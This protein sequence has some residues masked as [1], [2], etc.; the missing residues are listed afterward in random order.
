MH[1]PIDQ[2]SPQQ[3]EYYIPQLFE[4]LQQH[5]PHYA[6]NVILTFI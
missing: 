3:Q 5:Y 4:Y 1:L 2:S 6:N